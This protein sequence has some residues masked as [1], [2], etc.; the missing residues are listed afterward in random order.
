M[1]YDMSVVSC[2]PFFV[3]DKKFFC[4]VHL[5]VFIYPKLQSE[6]LNDI[7]TLLDL[8]YYCLQFYDLKFKSIRSPT[9]K[10]FLGSVT[11]VYK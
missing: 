7:M 4:A 2:R 6:L 1:R 10:A 9:K 5:P 8:L 3:Q 11:L